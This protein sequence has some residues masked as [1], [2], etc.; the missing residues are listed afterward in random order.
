MDFF[1]STRFTFGPASSNAP[2]WSRDG[3]WIYYSNL[4]HGYLNIYRKP[5]SGLN[6]D[7]VLVGAAPLFSLASSLPRS[8]GLVSPYDVSPDGKRFIV[9]AI[10]QGRTFP[11]NLVINWTAALQK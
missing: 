2:V 6:A 7:S 8:S 3:K 11:I 10:E 9:V 4:Q 5:S 1:V